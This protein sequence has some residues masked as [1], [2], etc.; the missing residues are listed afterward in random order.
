[1][2]VAILGCGAIGGVVARAVQNGEVAGA[3]LI[4]VVHAEPADPPG[5]PVLD[6]ESAIARADLVV[7]CAGQRALA[8]LGPS[9]VAAG[10][11]LLVVS[12]GAL[13]DDALLAKLRDT[14]PGRLH[15]C[16]GAIGG[17]D[18]LAATARM[19]GLDAVRIV[20]TKK[21]PALI[22]KW[23]DEPTAQRLRTTGE[24]VQLMRAPAREVTAAF[25]A[26]ANVA[27]SV[28]LAVGDWDL[29]EAT[30]VADPN[31]PLTSHVIT[32]DGSAGSYRFEIRN[33]PSVDN[34]ATSGVVPHAVLACLARLAQPT[35]A[36][37]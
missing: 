5:L 3:E 2:K 10:T 17:L 23:M 12:V 4:G 34:P 36:F 24:P 25:P 35:G 37:A 16:S 15:L 7:E 11:D 9:I 18:A 32:A 27:A 26:S 6:V 28:A 21:A 22:Q 30:V 19:G 8:E 13:A 29:V 33:H 31:A 1:M 14:G 20:T